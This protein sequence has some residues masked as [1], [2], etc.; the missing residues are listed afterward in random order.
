MIQRA[1]AADA[2]FETPD[3]LYADDAEVIANGTPRA[4]APRIAGVAAGGVIQ[5]GSSR[6][7]VTGSYVWGSIEYRWIPSSPQARM[8][9]GWATIVIAKLKDGSWRIVHIHSSTPGDTDSTRS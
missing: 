3:S 2:R 6:I 4:D 8:I 1:F 7:S 5:L 9:A